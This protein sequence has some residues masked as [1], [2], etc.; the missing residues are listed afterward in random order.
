MDRLRTVL[1]R[2]WFREAIAPFH[3]PR[4]VHIKPF[5]VEEEDSYQPVAA[6]VNSAENRDDCVLGLNVG[7]H[8]R[9]KADASRKRNFFFPA[10]LCHELSHRRKTFLGDTQIVPHEQ[11]FFL[12]RVRMEER[13]LAACVRFLLGKETDGGDLDTPEVIIL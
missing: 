8:N 7:V 3:P 4:R 1:N 10:Y 11:G 9:E 13:V 2:P 5:E 6:I 12:D